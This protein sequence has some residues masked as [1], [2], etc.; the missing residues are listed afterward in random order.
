MMLSH[1]NIVIT[2]KMNVVRIVTDAMVQQEALDA[3]ADAAEDEAE[4]G[5]QRE[6][7]GDPP[8]GGSSGVPSA[9]GSSGARAADGGAQADS[10]KQQSGGSKPSR[11]GSVQQRM[12]SPLGS[13]MI[14][15]P[16]PVMEV[17]SPG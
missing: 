12:Q 8:A 15:E 9:S 17:L 14:V 5:S 13:G 16:V 7:A 3:A 2:H 6:A 4:R 11:A 10:A 1:P